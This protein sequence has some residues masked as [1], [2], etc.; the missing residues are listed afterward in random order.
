MGTASLVI[1]LG[2]TILGFYFIFDALTTVYYT[3]E[4]RDALLGGNFF[5][6]VPLITVGALLL[7]KYDRDKKKEKN[8]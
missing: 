7:R 1:G 6:A 8:S 3:D 5:L 4:E 2:L